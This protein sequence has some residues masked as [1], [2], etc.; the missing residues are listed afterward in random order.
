[1]NEP[2]AGQETGTA[3]G[4]TQL[5]A[6]LLTVED[7]SA[8]LRHLARMAV[9]VVPDGPT[10][11]IALHRDGNYTA[12]IHAGH[13]PVTADEAQIEHGNGPCLQAIRTGLPVVS[14]DLSTETRWGGYPAAARA[15]GAQG[16]YAHPLRH[17][18]DVIGAINFYAHKPN[19]FTGPIQRIAAQFAQPA[20]TLL[21]GVLHRLSQDELIGQL[22][23]ALT[24]RAVIDQA[25]GI[26]TAQQRC[27][28]HEAF[29]ILRKMSQDRNVK[30]RDL[31][32]ELVHKAGT[33]PPHGR[34]PSP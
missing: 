12:I 31:A 7:T 4:L 16:I 26:L 24:S 23:A 18:D 28:P 19:I 21:N 10:C 17:G 33:Y 32:A 34:S 15:Q 11:A 14:Q 30:L 3:L 25:I 13:I 8:A 27:P 22:Q 5:A 20:A 2:S 1:M 6:L 9:T 29:R